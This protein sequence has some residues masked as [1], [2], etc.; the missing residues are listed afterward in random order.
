MEGEAAEKQLC[1]NMM[2]EPKE[3]RSELQDQQEP[4]GMVHVK[5][6]PLCYCLFASFTLHI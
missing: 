4:L 2:T 1:V 6:S 5:R 3:T